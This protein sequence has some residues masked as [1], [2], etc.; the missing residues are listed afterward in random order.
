MICQ[1]RLL[2]PECGAKSRLGR[3]TGEAEIFGIVGV[4]AAQRDA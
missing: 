1:G 4:V 2:R 3:N